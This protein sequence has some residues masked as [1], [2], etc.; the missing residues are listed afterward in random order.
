MAIADNYAKQS[1]R[2]LQVAQALGMSPTSGTFREICGAAIGYGL[3][4]GGPNAA[5]ITL[6]ALGRRIVAPLEAGDDELAR[7]EAVLT[8]SVAKDFLRKYDG[9]AL[10]IERIAYNVLEAAGVPA[11]ATQRVFALIIDNADSVGFLK[12]IK[13]RTYVD[14]GQP[15]QPLPI[16]DED[17][18]DQFAGD[19]M[20]RSATSRPASI[21]APAGISQNRKVFV[22]HGSNRRVVDQL[23]E[24]LIF[25][26]FEPIVSVDREAVSKPVPQ[27]VLDD[28]RSC[29]AGILHVSPEEKLL[30]QQGKERHA[31]NGNVLIE[32]GAAMALY[33]NRFLLLVEEG[34]SLPSNLQGLY[35]V[36][37]TGD[38]LGY[39]ATMKVLKAL[40]EFKTELRA[41]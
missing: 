16:P 9:S 11:E 27:K 36:R 34:T 40:N 13:D 2:P 18:V 22:S 3:T 24:L 26:D 14:L 32:I 17:D 39:Q 19:L 38:E 29:S 5:A 12:K 1:T 25:G 15:I 30:D 28:M 21:E 31:V 37:Y 35:E 23:K 7:R 4:D 33:G 20:V 10:P 41:G 6:T 8:P